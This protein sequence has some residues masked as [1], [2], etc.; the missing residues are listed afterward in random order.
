MAPPYGRFPA[1]GLPP[2]IPPNGAPFSLN[3]GATVH[4]A[5]AFSADAYGIPD[6]PRK[7]SIF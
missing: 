6:R 5:A 1:P 7:V 3:T 4:P 2:T